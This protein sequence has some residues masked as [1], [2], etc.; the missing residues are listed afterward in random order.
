M[1]SIEYYN[2]TNFGR[3]VNRQLLLFEEDLSSGGINQ[4]QRSISP[5]DLGDREL[6]KSRIAAH[7]RTRASATRRQSIGALSLFYRLGLRHMHGAGGVC[8]GLDTE[9]AHAHRQL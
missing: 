9:L 6:E 8:A 2:K 1:L 3:F 4:S 5:F 7:P